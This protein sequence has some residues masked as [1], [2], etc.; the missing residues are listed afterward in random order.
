MPQV[1][2]L[3]YAHSSIDCQ[4]MYIQKELRC[5]HIMLHSLATRWHNTGNS[6][7]SFSISA[8]LQRCIL[9][10]AE[11]IYKHPWLFARYWRELRPYSQH[12][13]D[14]P[15]FFIQM[16]YVHNERKRCCHLMLNSPVTRWH[17]RF[18]FLFLNSAV[19]HSC[20]LVSAVYRYL[21]F[22]LDIHQL[23]LLDCVGLY[24]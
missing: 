12:T 9:T 4:I 18:Q 21:P 22:I 24:L 13:Q 1:N 7:S 6:T 8:L 11:N 23:F 20:I 15:I 5:C 2:F 10:A 14:C 3:G 16:N 17:L 19:L